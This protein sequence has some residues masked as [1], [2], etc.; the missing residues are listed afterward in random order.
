LRIFHHAVR[1]TWVVFWASLL[2]L[3]LLLSAVRLWFF[4][5]IETYR[6]ELEQRASV[7]LNL[8]VRIGALSA[9]MHGFVPELV[10]ARTSIVEA[11]T[12]RTQV[13]LGDVRLGLD[14]LHWLRTRDARTHHIALQGA[15]LALR[16]EAD[17]EI[18][19]EGL[20]SHGPPP[21]WLF[22]H[23]R[24]ELIDSA[25]SWRDATSGSPPLHFTVERLLIRNA[26]DTHRLLLRLRMPGAL[27]IKAKLNGDPFARYGLSGRIYALGQGLSQEDGLALPPWLGVSLLEGKA[28][29]ELWSELK[30]GELT[31]LG[32]RAALARPVLGRL[33]DKEGA[34]VR[35]NRLGGWFRWQK[36]VEG[37]KLEA[38]RL[39][40]GVD[41]REWPQ[42]RLSFARRAAP[43]GA[44]ALR[45]A[46]SYLD[47]KDLAE[48]AR[49]LSPP[50]DSLAGAEI[51]GVLRDV[52]AVYD[53]GAPRG[54]RYGL[55]ARAEGLSWQ[56]AGWP[57]GQGWSGEVCGNDGRG[58]LAVASGPARLEWPE[59]FTAPLNLASAKGALRWERAVAGW[60]LEGSGLELTLPD[61]PLSGRFS[62]DVPD[63][64]QGKPYLDARLDFAD[65]AVAP[66]S[67]FVPRDLPDATRAWLE[68]AFP[69]GRIVSGALSWRGAPADYPFPGGEGAFA[70]ELRAR[71]GVLRFQPDWP[72]L[73][74]LDATVRFA[75]DRIQAEAMR[76]TIT[77]AGIR[78]V[79]ADVTHLSGEADALLSVEGEV[80]ATL[81]QMLDFFAQTPF[82]DVPEH[83][84][85]YAAVEGGGDLRLRLDVNLGKKTVGASGAVTLK[86]ARARLISTGLAIDKIEGVVEFDPERIHA[87]D[88]RGVLLEQPVTIAARREA[89]ELWIEAAG[90]MPLKTL[91]ERLPA[92]AGRGFAGRLPYRLGLGIPWSRT[93]R[94]ARVRLNSDLYGVTV[95]LPEPLGKTAAEPRVLALESELREGETRIPLE[96]AYADL[97]HARL[98]LTREDGNWT[99]PS[100]ALALGAAALGDAPQ[101]G[102]SLKGRLDSLPL[103]AWREWLSGAGAG[104]NGGIWR[105]IEL[106]VAHPSWEGRDLGAARL[107]LTRET[108]AW[109]GEFDLQQAA[110]RVQ[111]P[112]A[113]GPDAGWRLN[114]RRLSLP[115]L[116]KETLER[117]SGESPDPANLPGF[118]LTSEH[119]FWNELDLGR[120][121]LQVRRHPEGLAV[122]R[123]EV[124]GEGLSADFHGQ[125]LRSGGRDETRVDGKMMVENL[126]ALLT[127]AGKPKE[128]RDTPATLEW[129]LHWPDAPQ[130]VSAGA[131]QGEARLELG[132]GSLPQFEPGLARALGLLN[133]NSFMRRLTFDFSDIIDEGFAYDRMRGT[134]KVAGGQAE[135]SDFSVDGVSARIVASGRVGLAARDFQMVVTVAPRTSVVLPTIGTL[136][137]GPL[138]GAAVLAAQTLVG[139]KLEVLTETQYSVTGPWGAPEVKRLGRFG[140]LG[141]FQRA[142]EGMKDLSGIN[143]AE[144]ESNG[145][146]E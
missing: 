131:L 69:A 45:A 44:S 57:A 127:R 66:L 19:I 133:L 61:A 25:L 126:G 47:L 3:A 35:F 33:A 56:A 92:L 49:A 102:W 6:A 128:V 109:R 30:Q 54:G 34:R 74:N 100:G 38:N 124:R 71:D 129:K 110:G 52:R 137:G 98:S 62:L 64:P 2:A 29:F 116:E 21:P 143:N 93:A 76:A 117:V 140:P 97:L 1:F 115:K 59:H 72:P 104:G 125:W 85:E 83:L 113:A 141:V 130:R 48:W 16:R 27:T 111:V 84:R 40:L 46:A 36:E 63:A 119:L 145:Q 43:E 17:G 80:G 108:D 70:G 103:D 15:D 136:A 122:E 8:P 139:D 60:R 101:E 14:V 134:F 105:E 87:S 114:L 107:V 13:W 86:D 53:P 88:A 4:P 77:G 81:P 58:E 20:P 32:G 118:A 106:D 120:L 138:V 95:S 50:P 18:V 78:S 31:W 11:G 146:G 68:Q 41:G 99:A 90:D 37:W 132:K 91:E 5:T 26:N 121:D 28:D 55:C 22:G 89:G 10:L 142:W 39:R 73:E 82:R 7:A 79:S 96:L 135:T 144:T 112:L 24:F 51:S 23:G 9:R 12:G 42:A 67:V 65:V 75:G 123:G 94:Q